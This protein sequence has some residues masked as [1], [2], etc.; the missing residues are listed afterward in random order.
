MKAARWVWG[1]GV[2]KGPQLCCTSSASHPTKISEKGSRSFWT[3]GTVVYLS[4]LKPEVMQSL[5]AHKGEKNRLQKNFQ[6]RLS[7]GQMK[8][9]IERSLQLPI[10]DPRQTLLAN[11]RG[12]DD[13]TGA[14]PC[15]SR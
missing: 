15:M 1:K 13:E 4:F 14:M 11:Y 12:K 2:E 5:L 6:H 8:N 3:G 7:R 10:G 9:T